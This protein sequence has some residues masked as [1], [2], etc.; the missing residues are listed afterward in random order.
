MAYLKDL[1]SRSWMDLCSFCYVV[2]TLYVLFLLHENNYYLQSK[3]SFSQRP[4]D[5][6]F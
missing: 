1:L 2:Y 4:R 6:G 3:F 5:S